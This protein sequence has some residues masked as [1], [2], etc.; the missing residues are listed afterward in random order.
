MPRTPVDGI[1]EEIDDEDEEEP[2]VDVA[3]LPP[4]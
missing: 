2:A 1:Y 3:A 4:S